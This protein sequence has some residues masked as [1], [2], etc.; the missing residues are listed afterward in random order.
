MTDDLTQPKKKWDHVSPSQIK[1][2]NLCN[3][4]WWW[5]KIAGFRSPTTPAQQRGKDV[6]KEL[7]EY[8][9]TGK[10]PEDPVSIAILEYA[11]GPASTPRDLLERPL[12]QRKNLPVPMEGVIDLF[13]PDNPDVPR[14]SDY[15]T[16]SDFKWCKSPDELSYDPQALIYGME[17]LNFLLR[18][19]P[20]GLK[21]SEQ[22]EFRHVYGRT[23]GRAESTTRSVLLSRAWITEQ[24]EQR[25]AAVAR[26]MQRDSVRPITEVAFDTTAC[27]AYGGCPHQ[28]RCA[29]VGKPVLGAFQGLFRQ[30]K[31]TI[32]MST[33]PFARRAA[34]QAAPAKPQFA[35]DKEPQ[36]FVLYPV[37][38]LLD[39]GTLVLSPPAGTPEAEAP[40]ED[41]PVFVGPICQGTCE[42]RTDGVAMFSLSSEYQEGIREGKLHKGFLGSCAAHTDG[43]GIYL[44]FFGKNA[45]GEDP[46]TVLLSEEPTTNPP[47]GTPMGE[48]GSAGQS[49]E[50]PKGQGPFL[51]DGTRVR[52][53]KHDRLLIQYADELRGLDGDVL[54][55][56]RQHTTQK[57]R[58]W[59]EAD[60]PTEGRNRPQRRELVADAEMLEK[61]RAGELTA[62]F[63]AGADAASDEIEG[64]TDPLDLDLGEE[65]IAS[66]CE[67]GFYRSPKGMLV[68]I[69]G[70]KTAKGDPECIYYKMGART[71]I[72]LLPTQKMVPTNETFDNNLGLQMTVAEL[73]VLQDQAAA[74]EAQDVLEEAGVTIEPRAA[75]PKETMSKAEAVAT[76]DA[77]MRATKPVATAK[78]VTSDEDVEP[79]ILFVNCAPTKGFGE[80]VTLDDW[81][82]PY[83]ERVQKAEGVLH[84][85]IIDF[86]KGPKMI[87]GL[88]SADIHTKRLSLPPCL[89][90]DLRSPAASAV[91]EVLHRHYPVVVRGL[92]W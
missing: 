65:T 16:T 38:N 80:T 14:V 27:N 53:V 86:N 12:A 89:F 75:A 73:Q 92:S 85:G 7:E 48:P 84:Y 43:L 6:H 58:E 30:P 88:I 15:K 46:E 36:E 68:Y 67:E 72:A 64:V 17:M 3:T 66:E 2:Y 19:G 51:L 82:Q 47:D 79:T 74:K 5:E 41:V 28:S 23:R 1:T 55:A 9:L 25:I 71:T 57:M 63:P 60:Y 54:E 39:D 62:E 11:P 4:K 34:E 50:A 49:P 70:D 44:R 52:G 40:F 76:I 26:N 10:V 8:A 33:N 13:E 77:A 18:T 42:V 22:V 37:C 20:H 31:E 90:A 21:R 87:A 81:I 24:Y 83:V 61:V 91:V 32:D 59:V 56:W 69:T 35:P 78:I 45:A 29:S